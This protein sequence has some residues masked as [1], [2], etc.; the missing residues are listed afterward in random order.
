MGVSFPGSSLSVRYQH[1]E[2][3]PKWRRV[4]LWA[5]NIECHPWIDA[6]ASYGGL[7]H[8]GHANR[9]RQL[10]QCGNGWSPSFVLVQVGVG[11]PCPTLPPDTVGT[12]P[13]CIELTGT[14]LLSVNVGILGFCFEWYPL[15]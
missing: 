2:P 6:K 5:R 10:L 4:P 3:Q 7:E 9:G 11:G 12:T 14:S 13:C 1:R 8:S 15:S